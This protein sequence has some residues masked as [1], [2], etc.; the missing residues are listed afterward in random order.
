[1]WPRLSLHLNPRLQPEM[2]FFWTASQPSSSAKSLIKGFVSKI[3]LGLFDLIFKFQGPLLPH[4][5][6]FYGRF[7]LLEYFFFHASKFDNLG[8][9]IILIEFPS[10][11]INNFSPFTIFS[12]FLNLDGVVT[13]PFE[14]T[15]TM[16]SWLDPSKKLLQFPSRRVPPYKIENILH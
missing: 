14:E 4:T 10:R 2:R 12:S 8:I 13:W 1:M 7:F 5:F 6:N 3:I 15:V 9:G 16:G 11:K